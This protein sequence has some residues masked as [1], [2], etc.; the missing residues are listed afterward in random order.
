MKAQIQKQMQ[1]PIQTEIQL[2]E[3]QTER[4][5]QILLCVHVQAIYVGA[6]DWQF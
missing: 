5:G 6:F 3:A 1:K 2:R 4:Q